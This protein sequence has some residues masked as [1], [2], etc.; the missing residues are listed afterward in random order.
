MR[1]STAIGLR[2]PIRSITRSWRKR[3]SL[4]WSGSGM[5]PTSSRNRVPPCGQLDLADVGLDR[6]GEGAA[7]V[8][9]QL[10]LEQVLGDRGAVDRDELA[11]AAALLVDRAGEQFLAGAARA[12]QH[13]RDVGAGDALD[14]LATLS[15]SGAAV[16]HRAEHRRR[17]RRAS[18]RRF[19][20][21]ISWRWKARATIRPSSSMSTG[22]R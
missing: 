8:A 7:L 15:I 20:A 9:E 12:E 5:S 4:T 13:H 16:M 14:G 17:R 18:S 6:A 11:L 2:P 19:S 1:V 22:L 10:G 21:S 3:S